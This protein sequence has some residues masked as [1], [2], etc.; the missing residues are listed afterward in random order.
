M[1]RTRLPQYAHAPG[2][3][4]W[5]DPNAL[6]ART[7]KQVSSERVYRV[8]GGV[9]GILALLAD[10]KFLEEYSAW[11]AFVVEQ[12][13]RPDSYVYSL[14]QFLL[15]TTRFVGS[16][17]GKENPKFFETLPTKTRRVCKLVL[18]VAEEDLGLIK[19]G[20]RS[21]S[22]QKVLRELL[23]SAF[24]IHE[25][26]IAE[27][28][29]HGPTPKGAAF[30]AAGD[31]MDVWIPDTGHLN[32][33]FES[34]RGLYS[35][36]ADGASERMKCGTSFRRV[37]KSAR[38][39]SKRYFM[40][41]DAAYD[42][43]AAEDDTVAGSAPASQA[44]VPSE[45][46]TLSVSRTPHLLLSSKQPLVVGQT[47]KVTIYADKVAPLPEEDSQP[48]QVEVP[49]GTKELQVSAWLVAT[50]H[51]EVIGTTIRTFSIQ[52]DVDRST[53]A[54]FEVKVREAKSSNTDIPQL[55]AI[56][57]YN[58]RPCGSVT[59][60]PSI[61]AL[62]PATA[63]KTPPPE[64]S[65]VSIEVG[66]QCAD[67]T[68][69]VTNPSRDGRT[70][71]CVVESPHLA[72]YAGGV[73]DTW[74]LNKSTEIIVSE[75]F[76]KFIDGDLTN[77][78]RRAELKGA[79]MQLFAVA[80]N[81]FRDVFW[82]L[83][84]QKKPLRSIYIMSDEPYIPWE[85]M[86]PDRT[87]ATGSETHELPLGVQYA[88]GRW[89]TEKYIS[90]PQK[91]VMKDSWVFAPRYPGPD[92]KPL[93]KASDE[94]KYVLGLFTGDE[95]DP[96][97]FAALEAAL[98]KQA[99]SVLHFI[100]HGKSGATVH[101]LYSMD[102][103]PISATAILGNDGIR[104]GCKASKPFVFLNACEV[105]RPIPALLGSGGFPS[106]F[107]KIG[108]SGIIAPL[109]S[110]KDTVA[111]EVARSFYKEATSSQTEPLAATLARI[112]AKTYD[113]LEAEDSFAAYC[114][115]GDP[116]AIRTQ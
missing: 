39:A 69:T 58:G 12:P 61:E 14:Q 75:H 34:V 72:E 41:G 50:K 98:K 88:V 17:L 5:I 53:E 57:R 63:S 28:N 46:T 107:A 4:V 64:G 109:W 13:D 10:P 21:P 51:F 91:I 108:A 70:F 29:W 60:I 67:I 31:K 116:L 2:P 74:Y 26:A 96:A 30:R 79:G 40:T 114:F 59:V 32:L 6:G 93:E 45:T 104:S 86:V 78:Q 80:P 84:D 44:A 103:A 90:P 27:S 111:H 7:L 11:D 105:G 113:S 54:I 100:C 49:R 97:E 83:V 68:V 37:K 36:P 115:Y 24:D 47:T 101:Q 89:I 81:K 87:T 1:I 20:F 66:A 85:L 19:R 62:A 95:V 48:I 16:I 73:P 33:V 42:L 65:S 106:I 56:F 110:V 94:A 102:A 43:S 55:T 18:P 22:K 35:A 15:A 25:Y 23:K 99:R 52:P 38:G 77:A 82:K 92:P 3:P 8:K 76:A 112:R 9:D 71:D